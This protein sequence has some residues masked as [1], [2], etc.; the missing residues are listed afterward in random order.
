MHTKKV[1]LK[2]RRQPECKE[3]ITGSTNIFVIWTIEENREHLKF[4]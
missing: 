1:L 4:N 2:T 3:F